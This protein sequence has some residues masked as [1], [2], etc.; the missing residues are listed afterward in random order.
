MRNTIRTIIHFVKIKRIAFD[1]P[2]CIKK[3]VKL[4]GKLLDEKNTSHLAIFLY[5]E[6]FNK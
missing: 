6:F 1:I 4:F 2:T 3:Y 5:F